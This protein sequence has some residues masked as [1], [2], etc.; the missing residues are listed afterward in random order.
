MEHG[1][2]QPPRDLGEGDRVAPPPLL[3]EPAT[4]LFGGLPSNPENGLVAIDLLR[5]AGPLAGEA[6]RSHSFLTHEDASHT[7]GE[8]F[9]REQLDWDALRRDYVRTSLAV[10]A[11]LLFTESV[12]GMR[13]AELALRVG[14]GL[15]PENSLLRDRL[16]G[17]FGKHPDFSI[18]DIKLDKTKIGFDE[19]FRRTC[20]AGVLSAL[21]AFGQAVSDAPREWSAATID[22]VKP[23]RGCAGDPVEILGSGFG[24]AQPANVTLQF[25]AYAGGTI[26]TPVDPANW[27]D[28]RILVKAPAGVGSGL[29]GFVRSQSSTGASE[30]I[31][32]AAEELAG[33]AESCLGLPAAAFAQKLRRMG[34]ALGAPHIGD[35]PGKRFA[36]G[37]PKIL[38]FTANGATRALLRPRGPLLVTWLTD[39]ADTVA[40]TASGPPELPALPARLPVSGEQ[41]FPS[42]P[43]TGSWTGTYTL[44]ATNRCGS[45]KQTIDV[46]MR[47]RTALVLAGG[48]S[49]GAFEVGAVRCLTDVF[50]YRPDLL[51]GASVGSLNAAKLAEG[52]GALADLEG[53]WLGMQD[54]G[55][56][57]LPTTHVARLINDLHSLGIDY[58]AG[59]DL[60]DLLGVRLADSSWLSPDAELGIGMVKHILGLVTGVGAVFTLTDLIM[61]AARAGLLLAKVK[62]DIEKVVASQSI[63]VFDPVRQKI[64]AH[65]DAAKIA[66]SGLE[67]RIATVNLD[68]GRVRYIDQRGRFVD[69][70]FPVKLADAL[71]ASAS[72][73][74]AFPPTALPGGTYVDGGVRDNAPIRA[75]DLAGASTVIAV[76]PSPDHMAPNTYAGAAFPSIAARS[77]EAIF[78]ETWQDDLAPFRGYNAAVTVIAPQIET[79]SM[80]RVD[81]GL[82]QIDVDYGYMRAF[83][84]LQVDN[85]VRV[86][87]R[88]LSLAIATKRIQAWDGLEHNSEGKIRDE[89][90]AGFLA[91]K[92]QPVPD[93]SSLAQVRLIKGEIRAHCNERQ[94]LARTASA[95]PP[96]IERA[97]QQWERHKWTATITS[98][99]EGSSA[100]VGPGVPKVTPPAALPSLSPSDQHVIYRGTDGA[101][102]ELWWSPPTLWRFRTPPVIAGVTEA[103]GD[104]AAYA[105]DDSQ[106]VVYRGTYDLIHE[107]WRSRH[108]G[109]QVGT[110]AGTS[111]APP[112]AGDPAGYVLDGAQHVVYRGADKLIHELFWTAQAGWQIGALAAVAGAA[113]AA[114]DPAAYT[115]GGAQHVVYRGT[116]DL[117]HELWWSQ[118]GGWQ[119]GTLAATAGAVTAAGD[120]AGYTLDGN[121]HVVYRGADNLIHELVWTSQS[122]WQTGTLS[123]VAGAAAAAGDPAAY[124]LG[125]TQH[126]VYAGTDGRIHELWWSAQ[127]GWQIG[128]PSA[129]P[130]TTPATG[131]PAGYAV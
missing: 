15:D 50:D 9:D 110:L 75:A 103:T 102:H 74:I 112:S 118:Q 85:T 53:M 60:A 69:D 64:N 41:G 40:I 90:R 76:L 95:N 116:D 21:H 35:A 109:W 8:L 97:W 43:T 24:N 39:N 98:P 62:Q 3:A 91:N 93:A 26:T 4:T 1:E 5:G 18:R 20:V 125:A 66:K 54:S 19:L 100:H 58:V 131:R 13:P 11:T 117:I 101:I 16:F 104:P 123:T 23:A 33:A 2:H 52:P 83:D 70:D 59:I 78:D 38:R 115:L 25:P 130:G 71:Q 79:H 67:L 46:D 105:L 42:V 7:Y 80:L 34:P 45:V 122:G 65:I 56:L 94:N 48:G 61:G 57:Y 89:E 32:S 108:T 127:A 81:P 68:D 72:I 14:F 119:V 84:E 120:P 126:V 111:G 92:M 77:F 51:C 88:E 12:P 87:L 86:R 29:V 106:H 124:T 10:A 30:T 47:E 44:V 6:L 99:W 107:L 114:G 128:R 37:P 121:Q 63:F 129:A 22:E 113:T 28:T 73:P 36:G 31:G 49:K 96:G 27:S 17:R 55:D 82:V